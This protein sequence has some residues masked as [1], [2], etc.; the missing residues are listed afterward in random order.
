MNIPAL[1][2]INCTKMLDVEGECAVFIL[3]ARLPRRKL[4]ISVAAAALLCCYSGRRGRPLKWFFYVYYPL[5][6]AVLGC[7]HLM[8]FGL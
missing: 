8:V 2:Y 5:H 3:T 6:I 4:A 7:A 1:W